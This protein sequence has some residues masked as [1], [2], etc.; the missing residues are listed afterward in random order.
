M[1]IRSGYSAQTRSVRGS[2]TEDH[3]LAAD[4]LLGRRDAAN[5]VGAEAGP[6]AGLLQTLNAEDV[7]RDAIGAR[8]AGAL[9]VDG[10]APALEHERV[11]VARD[12]GR[13]AEIGPAVLLG[14]VRQRGGVAFV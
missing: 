7:E 11:A 2:G 5:R 6:L 14:D 4:M 8:G 9:R 3:H 12:C 1:F 13:L 10:F